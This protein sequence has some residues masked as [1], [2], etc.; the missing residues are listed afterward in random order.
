MTLRLP[1]PMGTAAD[2]IENLW[3]QARSSWPADLRDGFYSL[4]LL[5]A[6]QLWKE[7][8]GRCFRDLSS[9]LMTASEVAKLWV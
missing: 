5:I 6:W 4:F 2:S 7:R 8:S 3:S 9:F 1:R